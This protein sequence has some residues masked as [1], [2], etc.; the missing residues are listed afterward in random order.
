MT[1]SK[2]FYKLIFIDWLKFMGLT[3]AATAVVVFCAIVLVYVGE[4]III[5]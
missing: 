4:K 5:G 1:N 2:E 3:V